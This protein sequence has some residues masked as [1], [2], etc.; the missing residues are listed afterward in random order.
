MKNILAPFIFLLER[1]Q[2]FPWMDAQS[3]RLAA[4]FCGKIFQKQEGVWKMEPWGGM[5][6]AF[7]NFCISG[8]LAV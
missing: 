5:I 6:C 1:S 7:S 2:A 3:S 8:I 4:D